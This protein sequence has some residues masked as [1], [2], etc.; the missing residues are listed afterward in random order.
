[1]QET[2]EKELEDER[3]KKR[4][5]IKESIKVTKGMSEQHRGRRPRRS[6]HPTMVEVC[7]LDPMNL[8][9]MQETQEKEIENERAKK[10]LK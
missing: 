5:E 8:K 2:H 10:D 1:M 4:F 7:N 3:S 6:I 9:H